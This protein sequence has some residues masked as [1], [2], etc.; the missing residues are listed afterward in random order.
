MFQM[1][2]FLFYFNIYCFSFA[3]AFALSRSRSR[4]TCIYTCTGALNVS[5]HS[6]LL[7][8]TNLTLESN[9]LYYRYLKRGKMRE[10]VLN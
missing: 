1:V 9:I 3:F 5:R 2:N 8:K 10:L 4:R 6:A 7:S